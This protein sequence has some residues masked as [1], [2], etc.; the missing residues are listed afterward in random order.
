[1]KD[2]TQWAKSLKKAFCRSVFLTTWH[3]IYFECRINKNT[4]LQTAFTENRKPTGHD[5]QWKVKFKVNVV[6]NTLLQTAF[7]AILTTGLGNKKTR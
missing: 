1:M 3:C 4:L 7:L 5:Y 2:Y 6:K